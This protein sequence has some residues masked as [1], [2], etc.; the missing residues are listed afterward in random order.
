MRNDEQV[1]T[2]RDLAEALYAHPNA[3]AIWNRFRR[4][5]DLGTSSR[6]RELRIPRSEPKRF[7]TP[8]ST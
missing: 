2:P 4:H 3:E 7:T 1:E 6:S 8:L 5:I